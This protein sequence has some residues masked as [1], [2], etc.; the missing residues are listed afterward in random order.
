MSSNRFELRMMAVVAALGTTV[1]FAASAQTVVYNNTTG[2]STGM[3][4]SNVE[5]G[6]EITLAGSLRT[7]TQFSFNYFSNYDLSGGGVLRIYANDG[8]LVSGSPAPKEVLYQ[9]APFDIVKSNVSD[10]NN[11]Q[12]SMV[13]INLS[14]TGLVVPNKVTWTVSFSSVGGANTAGLLVYGGPTTGTSKEDFWKKTAGTWSLQLLDNNV[15][16]NFGAKLTAIPEPSTYA[17]AGVGA[18][19]WLA[20]A[21]YRRSKK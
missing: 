7:A 15:S 5:Y 14:S 13:T 4:V 20:L 9:S 6:D 11:A 12:G 21:G 17:L 18:I 19:G 8:P 3:H 2:V 16:A 10:P 1:P